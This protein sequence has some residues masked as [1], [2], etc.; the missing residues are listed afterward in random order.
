MSNISQNIVQILETIQSYQI[1]QCQMHHEKVAMDVDANPIHNRLDDAIVFNRVNL[2]DAKHRNKRLGCAHSGINLNFERVL[3]QLQTLLPQCKKQISGFKKEFKTVV[4]KIYALDHKVGH[5]EH[6]L[7]A[8]KLKFD[9][10][11]KDKLEHTLQQLKTEHRQLMNLL[12]K[13]KSD[14]EQFI[15]TETN[16]GHI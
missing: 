13:I 11:G 2:C 8:C 16:Y 6:D 10:C 1:V 14:I 5:L 7:A 4:A 9:A 15:H 12:S 3:E